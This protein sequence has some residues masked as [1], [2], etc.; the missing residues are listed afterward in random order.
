MAGVLGKRAHRAGDHRQVPRRR[1]PPL[2][3]RHHAAPRA[4]SATS[5]ESTFEEGL[6]EL[7]AWLEGQAAERP[8]RRGERGAG[9][10]GADGMSP[11]DAASSRVLIT[12]GAGF[13][14]TNLAHR[15]ARR[16]H[17]ACCSSTTSRARA[18]SR[19]CGGCARPTATGSTIEVADVRDAGAVR[20]GGGRASSAGVPLRRAGGGD[21]Q[22][23]RSDRTT[24]TSTR[25]ARSTCSRRSARSATPPPL[26]FTS[27]NKVYGEL[28][29]VA[30]SRHGPRYEPADATLARARHRRGPAARLPQPLRLLEGRRRP[31]RARLRPHLRPAGRRVPHEL[32]LRPAPVRHRGPGL[33]RALP[34]PRASRAG[35]SRSTATA[36][37]CATSCSST[38]WSRPSCWPQQHD[39]ASSG[40]AFNIGGGPGNTDQPAR[41]ARPDRALHGRAARG[42]V[43]GLAHRRPALLRLGY[44]KFQQAT[45][46]RPASTCR[47][48]RA[49]H[50]LAHHSRISTPTSAANAGMRKAAGA[51]R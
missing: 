9:G 25:A 5:R 15:L 27:T 24:S 44:A 32:H 10:A 2:L 12:G 17:A 50:S 35:R 43:R 14:G 38:I 40:Q 11:P 18:S 29:D 36:C 42:R 19:T 33:G 39:G 4:C 37:R 1:H 46:W 13:I 49:A 26:V 3:R 47:T 20:R 28:D 41:A 22:P 16:R 34:D 8:R 31:V 30:L 7:A 51:G 48:A 21:H 45:G 23:G 6:V